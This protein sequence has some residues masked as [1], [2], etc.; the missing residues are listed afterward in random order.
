LDLATVPNV[1]QRVSAEDYEIRDLSRTDPS[2]RVNPE[3]QRAIA[4][5]GKERGRG[6]EPGADQEL[7]F[8]VLTE[9]GNQKLIRRVG[10]RCD[11]APRANEFTKK[12]VLL[13]AGP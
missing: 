7:H 6:R 10:P 11:R 3:E 2:E 5:G 1:R 12:E 13:G 9:A 8:A 4:C